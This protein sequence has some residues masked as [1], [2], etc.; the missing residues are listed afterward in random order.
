MSTTVHSKLGWVAL[1]LV[2]AALP[3]AAQVL[4]F[5]LPRP[6]NTGTVKDAPQVAGLPNGTGLAVWKLTLPEPQGT[7]VA[8]RISSSGGQQGAET[9]ITANAMTYSVTST[10][11][12]RFL[13][14]WSQASGGNNR[15][16]RLRRV[17]DSGGLL[18]NEVLVSGTQNRER[19]GP[20]VAC[21]P[22]QC[23]AAWWE[24]SGGTLRLVGR[25]LTPVGAVSGDVV[26]LLGNGGDTTPLHLAISHTGEIAAGWVESAV[27]GTPFFATFNPNG[28]V[29]AAK[30]A[31][32][33]STV[34]LP[35]GTERAGVSSQVRV[36]WN[37]AG[38]LLAVWDR[39]P[40]GTTSGTIRGRLFN[41]QGNALGALRTLSEVFGASLPDLDWSDDQDAFA[42]AWQTSKLVAGTPRTGIVL[43][44]IGAD[45]APDGF[46]LTAVE[47]PR[48]THAGAGVGFSGPL[49]L[50][51][52]W[53]SE[54][55]GR[56][57][58]RKIEALKW[59]PDEPS[60]IPPFQPQP[61]LVSC[62]ELGP[63]ERFLVYASFR[64]VDGLY[65][66]ATADTVT[67][68][69]GFFFFNSLSNPELIAKI[70]DGRALNNHFWF[71][72]GALSNQEYSVA[73]LDRETGLTRVYFNA[74]GT[75][76]S[77]GD[78]RAFPVQVAGLLDEREGEAFDIALGPADEL[79][80]RAAL[81]E[82]AVTACAA[83]AE[84]CLNNDSFGVELEWQDLA[85]NVEFAH[86]VEV[87]N[88]GGY[89][90]FR[91]PANVEIALKILDG[92]PING[93]YWVFFASL[94]NVRFTLRIRDAGGAL[95]KEY[96]NPPGEFKSVADTAAF[97]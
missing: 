29:L 82:K 90:W 71:F 16:I 48:F 15:E 34:T 20:A 40:L 37:E 76:A 92:R 91:N 56:P 50:L 88:D 72:F 49:G 67:R 96:E 1:G 95:V 86:G 64:Q 79:A 21:G 51:T 68:D 65:N 62:S 93:K 9:A 26:T 17:G 89:F 47:R 70:V 42:L 31:L 66:R 8:H 80:A 13:V 25:F 97:P 73:A 41:A 5:S 74:A 53:A 84:L 81:S 94:T 59:R 14:V 22:A 87:A 6:L 27:S 61:D 18:G 24:K 75:L 63:N 69:A 52:A 60:C 11:D 57:N 85:G 30:T 32:D 7:L 35:G 19:F 54:P 23:L 39:L 77:Q 58:Q 43:R 10:P 44:I 12:E 83:G 3:G 2:L 4:P 78:T 28:S 33:T 46:E 36:A 55:E 38:Q 45:G